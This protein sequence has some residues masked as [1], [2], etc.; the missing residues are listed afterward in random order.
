[1]NPQDFWSRIEELFHAAQQQPV[2]E[3]GAWVDAQ[4]QEP[5]EV[6]REVRSLIT[7]LGIYEQRC[8][9]PGEVGTQDEEPAP[10][11]A[12]FGP[13]Q[14][15]KLIGRGGMGAVYLATRADGQFDQTV[16]L[17][18][19][20]FP[21]ADGEFLRKFQTERQLLASLTHP[22]ITRLLDGGVSSSGDPYL[23]MEYVDGLPLDRYCD[24]GKLSVR[25]RLEVFLQVLGAVEYAHRN[26]IV[27]RDLKP[28]NILVGAD[29]SAKLLDFGTALLLE[30]RS[31]VT[32]TRMRMLTPRYASPEQLRG[33]R[34]NTTTDVYSLGIILYELLTG[35]WPFGDPESVVVELNRAAATA[36]ALPPGTVVTEES[37]HNRSTGR[38][39]LSQSLKGD[40]TAIVMK[41]IEGDE[42]QRYSSVREFSADIESF[43]AGEPVR[44]HPQTSLY[45]A[46]KFLRRRW[47][48]A[49]AVA[50]FVIG[51]TAVA[52]I[53]IY[54]AR[55]ARERY[56]DLRSLTTSLLFDLKDAINDVPGATK[57]QQILVDRVVKN[58]DKMSQSSDDPALQ[59]EL[60]EAF[61]Q[62]G[63]LQGDPYV[64]NLGDS[65]GAL[66]NL[67]KS[68]AI[69]DRVGAHG[70]KD[71]GWLHVAGMIEQDIGEIRFGMD[72]T[73]QAVEHLK[74]SVALLDSMVPLTR[75]PVWLADA[76]SANGSLGDIYGQPGT[77]SLQDTE[78]AATQYKRVIELDEFTLKIAPSFLRSRRG[79]ALMWAKLGDLQRHADPAKS[80]EYFEQAIKDLDALPPEYLKTQVAQRFRANFLRKKGVALGELNQWSEAEASLQLAVVHTQ[81][82][83]L[84]DPQDS[85]A[86]YDFAVALSDLEDMLFRHHDDERALALAERIIPLEEK[87]AATAPENR[88]WQADLANMRCSRGTLLARLGR[89][90]EAL[91]SSKSGL[92]EF[93]KMAADK[94]AT[95]NILMQASEHYRS[96]EPAELRNPSKAVA[97]AER[98]V[99]AGQDKEPY[100]L[101]LLATAY[102]CAGQKD[103]ARQT[104][105]RALALIA[106]PRGK[107]VSYM[108]TELEGIR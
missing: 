11:L 63:E 82:G 48:S 108:R 44:A 34:A 95:S 19:I 24:A 1:M 62:L 97:L 90:A 9:S 101:Y 102:D 4:T 99:A 51:I 5:E 46:G 64:Q 69:V 8:Q 43:L 21:L 67:A 66:A 96:I 45:R 60:A 17:K 30:E 106:P 55:L 32:A 85:R 39:Q 7:G 41:A 75:N 14:P 20:G 47:L 93:E 6:R 107:L 84:E 35:A 27:H 68:K 16:A 80:L 88:G 79:M 83:T 40:L 12:R 98:N 70:P 91:R 71:A 53:A 2:A 86:I 23:V 72:Q 78:K 26:L 33:E 57:A 31:E 89:G 73:S 29:G 49:S 13:Y 28:A 52:L 38:Q 74:I 61:R 18:T 81:A 77:S 25:A 36:V 87:L 65:K 104:A 15:V 50:L 100:A 76:A 94:K 58:L 22:N 59:L 10:P 103:E 42:A 92:D 54:Q 3:R 56:A 105:A 37:A